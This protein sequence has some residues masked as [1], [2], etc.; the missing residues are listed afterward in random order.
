[1]TKNLSH[2]TVILFLYLITIS[3]GNS[4]PIPITLPPQDVTA[5]SAT[6]RASITLNR[7]PARVAFQL[8]TVG[9]KR[10]VGRSPWQRIEP[11]SNDF[12]LPVQDLSPG[13]D[14]EFR[15]IAMV[16]GIIRRGEAVQFRTL[17]LPPHATTDAADNITRTS[18]RLVGHISALVLEE[19]AA[20][21]YFEFG[22]TTNYTLH[23]ATIPLGTNSNEVLAIL[24]DLTPDTEY[25][26]R[27]V[28][29][30]AAGTSYGESAQ[31]RTLGVPPPAVTGVADQ[32]TRTSARLSGSVPQLHPREQLPASY[33]EIGTTTNYDR[34]VAGIYNSNTIVALVQDLTP[35]TQYHFRLVLTNASGVSYGADA[36]FQTLPCIP[37]GTVAVVTNCTEADLLAAI[38]NA[39][40]VQF[41]A[42]GL[43][44]LTRPIDVIC[45]LK[46]DATGHSVTLS[47]GGSNRLFNVKSGGPLQLI[48]LAIVNG[49]AQG[50]NSVGPIG[51]LGF[52]E[53]EPGIG[54]AMLVE[55]SSVIATE[56]RFESNIASGG[57]AIGTNLSFYVTPGGIGAGGAVRAKSSL[58]AFTNCAFVNNT[59]SGGLGSWY[60][61]PTLSRAG[62]APAFGGAI[63]VEDS[64]LTLKGCNLGTNAAATMGG[65]IHIKRGTL[66]MR[67]SSFLGNRTSS[68]GAALM[69]DGATTSI[70]ASRFVGNIAGAS[71]D[72]FGGGICQ[73][74]G[75]MHI[76][77]T[78]FLSNAAYGE[79][80]SYGSSISRVIDARH[81]HGGGLAVLGGFVSVE[82]T[83]FSQNHAAG[84]SASHFVGIGAPRPYANSGNGI[85]GG[86]YNQSTGTVVNCSFYSNVAVSGGI[87]TDI[88]VPRPDPAA[89][90]GGAIANASGSLEIRFSTIATNVSFGGLNHTNQSFAGGIFVGGGSVALANSI[91]AGNSADFTNHWNIGGTIT[92]LGH[93]VSSDNANFTA[94]GSLNNI[95]PL[96]GPFGDYG[97]LTSIFPLL[98]GS[99]CIDAGSLHSLPATDQ[100]G[101]ARPQRAAPDV[102]AYERE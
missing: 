67:D 32:I 53:G 49:R 73:K 41:A 4:A 45:P 69:N 18:A 100:R 82:R 28:V 84:G 35:E 71:G 12:S 97:G 72:A 34:R 101:V 74:A 81:G 83:T 10:W 36:G 90:F 26:F 48:H 2:L 99:P 79:G 25:Y 22:T 51:G 29:T 15:A 92:D 102:G 56:C 75:E 43:I 98:E 37:P 76:S 5:T 47:G 40:E 60:S 31:F 93:N 65:A 77:D 94:G 23:T 85:G 46:L 27:L 57:S 58:L 87:P 86:I 50:T 38:A 6:L 59:V 17:F 30:N 88:T 68:A 3:R 96:L 11:G 42:D 52:P 55:N 13:T 19:V 14:Y 8:R 20:G 80:F 66:D 64:T 63:D 54:G 21:G 16:N 61:F 44:T 1:M 39:R 95:D 78:T 9:T 89:G 62:A 33:F 24:E 7:R 70:L 91:L